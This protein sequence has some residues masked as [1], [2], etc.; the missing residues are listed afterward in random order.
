MA[1]SKNQKVDII[2]QSI[3]SGIQE[4]GENYIQEAILKIQKFKKY[5]HITWHFIGKIQSN[6]TKLVAKNFDWCQTVD[7]EKIVFLLNKYR[8]KNLLPINVLIQINISKEPK[9]NGID[10]TEYQTLAKIIS[11]MPNINLRGIMA[12]PKITK[13]I[14]NTNLQYQII[15]KTFHQLKQQY[16]SVDTLSLG[17]SFDIENSLLNDSNMIRIGRNIFN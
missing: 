3:L 15:K 5:K 6:K 17:T 12:M 13:N 7:R 11:S 1:V 10:I 2:K 14:V 9:K 8:P 16:T 4:F